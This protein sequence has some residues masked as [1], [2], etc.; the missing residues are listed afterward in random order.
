MLA[1]VSHLLETR[2][3][4]KSPTVLGKLA[5]TVRNMLRWHH[6]PTL[7]ALIKGLSWNTMEEAINI[8]DMVLVTL[9]EDT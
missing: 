8:V 7:T 2:S 4:K 6:L 3:L 5:S 1:C 9:H